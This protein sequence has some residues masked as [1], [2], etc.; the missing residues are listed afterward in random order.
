MRYDNLTKLFGEYERWLKRLARRATHGR[1]FQRLQ[2]GDLVRV[3]NPISQMRGRKG[4]VLASYVNDDCVVRISGEKRFPSGLNF[5]REELRRIK[6][7][8]S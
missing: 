5:S 4:T 8:Q 1:N 6:R 2:V 3:V 7:T